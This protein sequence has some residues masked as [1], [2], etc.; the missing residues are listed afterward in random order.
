ML[1]L[2]MRNKV[3]LERELLVKKKAIGESFKDSI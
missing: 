1:G 3:V 2:Q